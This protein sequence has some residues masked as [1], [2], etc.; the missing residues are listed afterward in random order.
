MSTLW[1]TDVFW[2]EQSSVDAAKRMTA[3]RNRQ[4]LSFGGSHVA[5][6]N[7]KR[8]RVSVYK[9]FMLLSEN[10]RKFSV[11]VGI[12]EKGDSDAL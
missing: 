1:F 11:F 10:E 9:C 12:L 6:L 8:S 5:R 3:A 2:K 7:F 4:I